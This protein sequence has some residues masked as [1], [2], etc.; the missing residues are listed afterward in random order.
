MKYFVTGT[1]TNVGKTV[2]SAWLVHQLGADYWKPIQSGTLE[3][4]DRDVIQDLTGLSGDRIH[5]EV[6][7]FKEPLS[8]HAA[9]ALENIQIDLDKITMLQTDRPLIVEGAGGVLVPLN[10]SQTMMDLMEKLAIPVI[11]V[12]RSGLG[13][14]NHTCLTLEALRHRQIPIA[15]VILNGPLNEGNRQAIENYGRVPILAQLEKLPCLS[16]E[17][18][19]QA[20]G[21]NNLLQEW[22]FHKLS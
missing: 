14:I 19:S 18:L 10:S 20:G 1:D 3:G 11:V 8:P 16:R 6:Y 4:G 12:A 5:R 22:R 2:V 15:G 21:H 17:S 13:T 9:A 7:A